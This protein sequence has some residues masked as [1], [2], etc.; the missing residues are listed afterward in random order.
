MSADDRE[1]RPRLSWR[2]IDQRRSGTHTPS[3]RPRGRHAE[4]VHAKQKHEALQAADSL[5]TMELGGQQG[6]MLAKAMRD[7][8]GSPEL[9]EA[10]RAYVAE[11]GTP[12]DSALLSLLLDSGDSALIVLALEALLGLSN[13]DSLERSAGLKS[14]LRALSQHSD[15]TIAG[16]SEEL[17]ESV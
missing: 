10:C 11:I 14:Q 3:D 9:A 7:A 12:N 13:A 8:H 17:L 6:A 5:F 15:D 2:E 1:D 16:I 4:K